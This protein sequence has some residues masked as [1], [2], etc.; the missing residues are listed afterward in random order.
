MASNNKVSMR[1]I[2]DKAGV[3]IVSVSYALRGTPGVSGE[4]RRKILAIADSIG[5]RPDPLLS[6]LMYH[7]RTRRAPM[8]PH[9]IAFLHWPQDSFRAQVLRGAKERAEKRGYEIDVIKMIEIGPSPRVLQRMLNAR[10]VAGV[11]LGPSPVRDFSA[12]L[13]WSE[14]AVMLTSY[15]VISPPFH[16]VVANQYTATQ[17]ALRKLRERGYRRIGLVV[18]PWVEER[19]NNFHSVAFTW[20]AAQ[21]GI[22]PLLCYHDPKIHPSTHVRSW[23]RANH[24]DALV[25]CGPLDYEQV[26]C[27]TLGR[28]T[29]DRLGIVSL[30]YETQCGNSMTVDYQ[31]AVLGAVAFDQLINQIHR[32]ERGIPEIQQTLSVEGRW[33]EMPAGAKNRKRRSGKSA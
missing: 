13:D 20:E 9:N 23:Y 7:L 3:S 33:L 32:G 2:A 14:Y 18:P 28:A 10:G 8:N 27:K 29:V 30:N 17:L 6:H 19:V 16:R 26:L 15:S 22:K 25:L 1:E 31:P 24:P 4:T 11:I 21:R 5:Y 12:L